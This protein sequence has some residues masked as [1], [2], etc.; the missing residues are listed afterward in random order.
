LGTQPADKTNPKSKKQP[1]TS[2]LLVHFL[3][4]VL[5]Q[6]FG[7]LMKYFFIFFAIA[8]PIKNLIFRSKAM[9]LKIT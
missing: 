6:H 9:G 1:K 5:P 8:A 4:V 2:F 7:L 3:F